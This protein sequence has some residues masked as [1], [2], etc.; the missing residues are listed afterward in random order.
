MG[1][2]G[3]SKAADTGHCPKLLILLGGGMLGKSGVWPSPCM[4][5]LANQSEGLTDVCPSL[6][7][8]AEQLSAAVS[9]VITQ[10]C[11]PLSDSCPVEMRAEEGE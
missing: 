5:P 2:S 11:G 3:L 4:A 7:S 8:Q 6:G 10:M 1:R 9:V